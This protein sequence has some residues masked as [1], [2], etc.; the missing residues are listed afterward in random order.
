MLL[1][2][3]THGRMFE[4]EASNLNKEEVCILTCYSQAVVVLSRELYS[5]QP[6]RGWLM[7]G[8]TLAEHIAWTPMILGLQ[9]QSL[10]GTIIGM[11]YCE[12]S[13]TFTHCLR[14]QWGI[15]ALA[16]DPIDTNR[17]YLAAGLYTI[18]WDPKPGS[19]LRS[20]DKGNTWQTTTLPFK[21]GGNMPGR[22]AGEVS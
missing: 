10:W 21:V 3:V 15:D 19:I 11:L 18:S 5:T 16:T 8:Q 2:K 12:W 17:V 4:L 14:N 7:P 13:N 6:R 9:L 1:V 22:G 20:S